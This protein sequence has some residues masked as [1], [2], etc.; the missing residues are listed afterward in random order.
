MMI[1]QRLRVI[2]LLAVAAA[3][4][5]GCATVSGTTRPG[6]IDVRTLDVGKYS[7]RPLDLRY[8]YRPRM[9]IARELATQRLADHVVTGADIDP[10]LTF[11][12]GAVSIIDTD[13]ATQVLAKATEPVLVANK[14]MFGF[15]VGHSDKQLEESRKTPAGSTFT[16]VTVLQF[17]DA[18]TAAKAATELDDADFGV[19]PDVNERVVLPEHADAHS[20]WRPGIASLGS[21]IAH[22]SYVV[23]TYLGVRDPDLS[24]LTALADKVFDAQLPLLD[25]LPPL[26]PEGILRLRYDPDGMLRRTLATGVGFWPDFR[27]QAVAE[28]RGFLHRVSDQ[29]FWRRLVTDSGTDRFSTSGADYDGPSMLFRTRDAQAAKQLADAILG[30]GYSG[31]VDAP[32]GFP[33]AKCGET[34]NTSTVINRIRRYRCVVSYRQYTAVVDSDQVADA[35][36]R[37]AAQYALLANS[38]W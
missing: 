35:H 1:S 20:H 36:Q 13:R 26:N 37:A 16:R 4:L 25:S 19:A 27:D 15:S 38:T 21:T 32:V 30:H 28:P 12:T 24:A 8:L 14:M 22:G 33:D 17:P 29:A 5:T 6:E 23:N 34:T 3:A 2:A 31:K 7:T 9:T 18:A 10:A 11:G